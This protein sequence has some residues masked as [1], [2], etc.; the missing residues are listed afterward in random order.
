L[1][2]VLVRYD[3]EADAT[4]IQLDAEAVVA[5]TVEVLDG[6]L[7]VDVDE[8]GRPIGIEI[9]CAPADVDKSALTALAERFPV[10]DVEAIRRVLAGRSAATA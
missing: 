5:R 1:I 10:L 8:T 9:L 6:H 2:A 3:S 4:Y 7:L